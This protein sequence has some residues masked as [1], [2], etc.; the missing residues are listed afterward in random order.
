MKLSR[1]GF[2]CASVMGKVGRTASL[3]AMSLSLDLGIT[4]FDV[5][6][7]YGFGCA[8]ALLG[9]FIRGRRQQVTVTTKFGIVPPNLGVKARLAMPLARAMARYAPG[10][11]ARLRRESGRLLS[12]QRFD[13]SYARQALHTSLAQLRT[14]YVDIFMLHEPPILPRAILDD[15][16]D[17]LQTLVREGKVRKWGIAYGDPSDHAGFANCEHE[18]LQAECHLNKAAAWADLRGDARFRIAMRPF[19]GGPRSPSGADLQR[20]TLALLARRAGACD[21]TRLAALAPLG[22]ASTLAGPD[23]SV[24]CAMFSESSIRANVAAMQALTTM[25]AQEK[26]VLDDLL[27]VDEDE[28]FSGPAGAAP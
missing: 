22:I 17:T 5:A 25:S 24:V 28:S 2:G 4:H 14:D 1:L 9:E 7:S 15:I 21:N 19:A 13:A 6:R 12:E 23:A 10:L 20:K 18:V 8:E 26:V 16:A 27:K 3:R 11:Q